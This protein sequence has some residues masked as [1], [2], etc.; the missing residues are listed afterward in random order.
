LAPNPGPH[1]VSTRKFR[2]RRAG[3]RIDIDASTVTFSQK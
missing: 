2:A 1:A 3:R